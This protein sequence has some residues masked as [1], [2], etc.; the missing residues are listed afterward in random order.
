MDFFDVFEKV[1]FLTI[2]VVRTSLMWSTIWKTWKYPKEVWKSV[3]F[4]QFWLY[5]MNLN[6]VLKKV[7]RGSS[8]DLFPNW[9]FRNLHA[10]GY[11]KIVYI[12]WFTDFWV[13][14]SLSMMCPLN[15]F[16]PQEAR[17]VYNKVK[18]FRGCFVFMLY[19]ELLITACRWQHLI[20]WSFLF[21]QFGGST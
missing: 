9:C 16:L 2:F 20:V 8:H 12:C 7:G 10:L 14:K 21:L 13:N 6:H 15:V 4:D 18:Y 5:F 11:P 1:S 19:M 17:C 3:N